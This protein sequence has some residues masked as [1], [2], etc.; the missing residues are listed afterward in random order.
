M[1]KRYVGFTSTI[2]V[3]N[4]HH[5]RS[6]NIEAEATN[7][8]C[9]I[10]ENVGSSLY[11]SPVTSHAAAAMVALWRQAGNRRIFAEALVASLGAPVPV[12]NDY[13]KVAA[14]VTCPPVRFTEGTSAALMMRLAEGNL[15]TVASHHCTF[16][17]SQ[18]E[19]GRTNF[20]LIPYG[21]NGLEDR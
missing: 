17:K 8:A 13:D 14:L 4:D 9:V 15:A 18:K 19:T 16:D 7:R 21:L 11:V 1:M 3:L 10:A 12:S 20:T 2:T 5:Y 6:E